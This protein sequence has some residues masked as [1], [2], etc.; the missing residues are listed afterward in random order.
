MSSD[1][2]AQRN[3]GQWV[4]QNEP[5]NALFG[6]NG[7]AAGIP[8]GT[9]R[10]LSPEVAAQ[11]FAYRDTWYSGRVWIGEAFNGTASPLGYIDDRHVCLVSGSRGGKGVG[12]IVP[13]LCYWPGLAIIIVDPKGENADGDRAARRGAGSPY[14]HAMGQQVRILDPFGEV[15][16]PE[17]LKAR[18]NPLDAI[19]PNSDYAVDDA[20]RVAASL[21][22]VENRNDPY[23][24]EAARNLIKGLIRFHVLTFM[25]QFE[26]RR[27]LVTVRR[28]LSQL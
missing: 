3:G 13:N 10:W 16:L 9:A 6:A 24:E 18:Y 20:G 2:A 23:W 15:D 5:W 12:V 8:L 1:I 14:T 11:K 27:N 28:L 4:A 25:P 19:D 21:V 22:V 26:E 17:E 7:S